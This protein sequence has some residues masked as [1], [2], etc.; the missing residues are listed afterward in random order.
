MFSISKECFAISVLCEAFF[1]AINYL[2]DILFVLCVGKRVPLHEILDGQRLT[3]KRNR[4]GGGDGDLKVLER[5][6]CVFNL[7][8]NETLIQFINL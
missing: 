4:G 2:C 7:R 8:G 1:R 6:I 5:E 3:T